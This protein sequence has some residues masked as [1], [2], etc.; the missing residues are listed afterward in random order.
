MG[1]AEA[2][3]RME[4]SDKGRAAFYKKFWK[5]DVEDPRLYDLTIETSKVPYGVAAEVVAS[6]ARAKAAT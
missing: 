3:H 1:L 5:V 4:K 2:K 6:V